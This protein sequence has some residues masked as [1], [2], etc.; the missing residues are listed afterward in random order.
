[1]VFIVIGLF[2]R[3]VVWATDLIVLHLMVL[4]DGRNTEDLRL[5]CDLG[6]QADRLCVLAHHV[7]ELGRTRQV[8]VVLLRAY[9][10]LSEELTF[11]VGLRTLGRPSGTSQFVI[12]ELE[13]VSGIIFFLVVRM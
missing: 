7:S 6:G 3:R 2:L 9:S 5:A 11:M 10:D 4:K 12:S 1:M 8:V 13:P